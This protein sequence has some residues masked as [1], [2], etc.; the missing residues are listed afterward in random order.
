[1][2]AGCVALQT[3]PTAERMARILDPFGHQ[4]DEH[5]NNL[6]EIVTGIADVYT[7]LV[8]KRDRQVNIKRPTG[9][10]SSV[11]TFRLHGGTLAQDGAFK[12]V[13][14]IHRAIEAFPCEQAQGFSQFILKS[15]LLD[16]PDA[17][18]KATADGR[19]TAAVL[20]S[21]VDEPK[22]TEAA[23][24]EAEA[25]Q[26]LQSVIK[27]LQSVVVGSVRDDAKIEAERRL[28]LQKELEVCCCEAAGQIQALRE[29]LQSVLV[30]FEDS[31]PMGKLDAEW[32]GALQDLQSVLKSKQS[33]VESVRDDA[34]I[35]AERRLSLRKDLEVCCCVTTTNL[36]LCEAAAQTQA[37]RE[38]LQSVRVYW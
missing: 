25:L 4:V 11:T 16:A 15:F 13:P 26:D 27:S 35:E 9:N 18:L 12:D 7:D 10:H 28:S 24:A 3:G 30:K 21:K 23:S 8:L 19:L 29:E 32:L 37:L 33:V 34:K 14:V 5:R 38:E 17:F 20:Q 1:M 2:K 36:Q 22:S 6:P 31:S